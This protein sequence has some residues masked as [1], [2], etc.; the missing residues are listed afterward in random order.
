VEW[1]SCQRNSQEL[2]HRAT[3]HAQQAG[4]DFSA[5]GSPYRNSFFSWVFD[6]T[7]QLL[8]HYLMLGF[9]L[10]LFNPKELPVSY[11]YLEYLLDIRM[12]NKEIAW[13]AKPKKKGKVP[14]EI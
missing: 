10:E 4:V 14:K 8:I 12:R 1:A 7:L 11:W 5:P 6:Q 2:D 9:E 13:R 3:F